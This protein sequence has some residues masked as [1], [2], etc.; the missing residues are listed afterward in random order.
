MNKLAIC[1]GIALALSL[2]STV[3]A[4]PNHDGYL[5]NSTE[6]IWR[7]STGDCWHN[8]NYSDDTPAIKGCPGYQEPVAETPKKPAAPKMVVMDADKKFSVYFDFDSTAVGDLS[9][10]VSYLS[11]LD[12]LEGIRLIGNADPL[13]GSQYNQD[14]SMRRA[15]AVAAELRAAGVPGNKI[16]LG[17]LGDTAPVKLCEGERSQALIQCLRPDRRVD[18]QIMGNKKVQQ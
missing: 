7:T 9:E 2:S 6:T 17:A 14:L 8:G 1:T 15:E 5:S 3:Q 4:H 18:V 10:I 11:S 12:N 16:S 13:G